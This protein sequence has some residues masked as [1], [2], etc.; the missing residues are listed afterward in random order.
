SNHSKINF[1]MAELALYI[2]QSSIDIIEVAKSVSGPKIINFGRAELFPQAAQ[3]QGQRPI[4]TSTM[5]IPPQE[6]IISAIKTLLREKKIRSKEVIAALPEESV[7]VR[8][9]DMPKLSPKEWQTAVRFEAKKYIPFRMEEI[10]S[11]FQVIDNKLDFKKMS[12]VFVA[13]KREAL[14]TQLYILSQA[15]LIPKAIEIVPFALRRLFQFTKELT[16][17]KQTTV[18][19]NVSKNTGFI[20]VLKEGIP[21]LIRDI[22]I[23]G[24]TNEAIYENLMGELRLS[25]GYFERQ[26]PNSTIGSVILSGE[27]N[28]EGWDVKMSNE[29][30]ISTKVSNPIKMIKGTE[31]MSAGCE[32]AMGLALRNFQKTA[33]Q[34]INLIS[35]IVTAREQQKLYA[36]I[37]VSEVI[38]AALL[39]SFLQSSMLGRVK[40]IRQELTSLEQQGSKFPQ[41]LNIMSIPELEA[42]KQDIQTRTTL[43]RNFVLDR[44]CWTFKF[45]DLAQMLPDQVWLTNI[46][47]DEK[48]D[49]RGI[50]RLLMI[51]G[52]SWI[53]DKKSSNANEMA[54]INAYLTNIKDN[55][56]FLKG[57]N[58]IEGIN[59]EKQ[60]LGYA[61]ATKFRV[62]FSNKQ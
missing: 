42:K 21:C 62:V 39:L 54:L 32:I 23:T 36:K 40:K 26:F 3:S 8:F 9:F 35:D 47:L 1:K 51:E 31:S 15:G 13:A 49:T 16:G 53:K 46:S 4:G 43:F 33:V 56:E 28:F 57:F 6:R 22:I 38:C 10:V 24:E 30:K 61:D 14:N 41:D 52:I 37:L 59:I 19:V 50:V 12:V 5:P 58:R 45:R 18:I 17:E 20:V 29:L 2:G 48:A 25:I 44:V 7:T 60:K 34:D 11:D 27:C 55:A